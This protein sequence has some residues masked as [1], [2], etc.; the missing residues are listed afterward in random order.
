MTAWLTAWLP[1]SAAGAVH[2]CGA[3]AA[4]VLGPWILF[5]RKGDRQHRLYGYTYVAIMAAVNV[6]ALGMYDITGRPNLFHFFAGLSLGTIV[7]GVWCAIRARRTARRHLIVAHYYFMTWAYF[8]L[9]AAF[10]SQVG[11]RLGPLPWGLS[12]FAAV[13]IG[14]LAAAVV[15][16]LW[17]QH[18]ATEIIRR[19][20]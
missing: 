7:P 12:P 11:T 16:N 5:A 4:L 6:T 8:G 14:T 9:L 3:L 17:I 18:R 2:F 20:G 15:A 1:Q 10:L 13:G 19:Y